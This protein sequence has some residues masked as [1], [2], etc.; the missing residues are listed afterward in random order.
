MIPVTAI[1]IGESVGK[2]STLYTRISLRRGR[3]AKWIGVGVSIRSTEKKI[4]GKIQWE[5]KMG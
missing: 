3:E 4:E 5:G 1:A 2:T